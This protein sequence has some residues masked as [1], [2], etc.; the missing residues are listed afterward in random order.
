MLMSIAVPHKRNAAPAERNEHRYGPEREN[1]E[2]LKSLLVHPGVGTR[3][4][5]SLLP[6]LKSQ[7]HHPLAFSPAVFN[8]LADPTVCSVHKA[9]YPPG[10]TVWSAATREEQ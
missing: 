7:I 3:R 1:G 4:M 9:T 10:G 6:H 5:D 2:A 8:S